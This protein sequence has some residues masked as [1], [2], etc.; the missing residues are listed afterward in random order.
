MSTAYPTH[1]QVE[2]QVAD[3]EVKQEGKINATISGHIYPIPQTGNTPA[4]EPA[5][6]KDGIYRVKTKGATYTNFGGVVVP[7]TT[8]FIYD[9][10]VSGIGV[11]P[12]YTL[13]E[14]D[15]NITTSNT[16]TEGGTNAFTD[17]GAF[18]EFAKKADKTEL[19]DEK[20]KYPF[21]ITATLNGKNFL[22][23]FIEDIKLINADPTKQYFLKKCQVDNSGVIHSI[24][25]AEEDGTRFAV[26]YVTG[27]TPTGKQLITQAATT[28][29]DASMEILVNWDNVVSNNSAVFTFD[30]TAL[31]KSVITEDVYSKI[32]PQLMPIPSF[33]N[34]GYAYIDDSNVLTLTQNLDIP[35][36]DS[37][38]TITS[39]TLD[40]QGK[41][42]GLFYLDYIDGTSTYTLDNITWVGSLTIQN[43]TKNRI[44]I[45]YT[46][47]SKL[48]S[49]ILTG[50]SDNRF[51]INETN[52][53]LANTLSQII[54][55]VFRN[56][57]KAVQTGT[58]F[59]IQEDVE[60]WYGTNRFVTITAGTYSLAGKNNRGA[61]YLDITGLD[62]GNPTHTVDDFVYTTDT[63]IINKFV[64]NRVYIGYIIDENI[65]TNLIKIGA[66]DLN[67]K[68]N[69]S[70]V[71]LKTTT[72]YG[73]GT[74]IVLF[75][76]SITEQN[77]AYTQSSAIYDGARG[78]WN[79]ANFF[80]NQR[81][82][83]IYNAG[84]GGDTTVGMLARIQADVIDKNPDVVFFMGGINDINTLEEQDASI[85]FGRIEQIYDLLTANGIKIIGSLITPSVSSIAW[86]KDTLAQLNK[87]LSDYAYSNP[88]LILVD[89]GKTIVDYTTGDPI[90][91]WTD[92]THPYDVAAFEM[93]WEVA[94]QIRPF[95]KETPF[96]PY[97]KLDNRLL[98]GN[99][100]MDGN[101][102]GVATGFVGTGIAGTVFT[103]E[104]RADRLGEWQVITSP[105]VNGSG[106]FYNLVSNPE[107][108]TFTQGDMIY[109]ACEIEADITEMRGIYFEIF[110]QDAGYGTTFYS[111]NLLRLPA[112][113]SPNI[114]NKIFKGT[115]KTEPFEIPATSTRIR[116]R[117]F[118]DF[119]GE[120]KVGRICALKV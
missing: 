97:S 79:M 18:T 35:F 65:Y 118:Y 42:R 102:S 9:I 88:N 12:V 56:D 92:N 36:R 63:N 93:G 107:D 87:L 64:P 20:Y 30:Q 32:D 61:V 70:D 68:A 50:G 75:G 109:G 38:I 89:M 71:L 96:L 99:A 100:F 11:T 60:F 103:K 85:I 80:L 40:L 2:Q 115:F 27:T 3:L 52:Y 83:K 44:I 73:T 6:T 104:V 95:F 98:N 91:N 120:I 43:L 54:N 114:E 19:F 31:L 58:D 47:E 57:G 111:A 59:I 10:Q 86:K 39:G 67:L 74:K 13:I 72:P 66:N 37:F 101:V 113:T 21:V 34:G 49:P 22:T 33:R 26:T 15:V 29:T 51:E 110:T 8:G 116:V 94:N 69:T 81:F 106:N 24:E 5:P 78:Y 82:T 62:V 28:Q 14:T 90:A 112:D 53:N 48:Y 23:K 45:G 17:G 55:P 108:L 25:I 105:S 16:P 76:D 84:I 46:N 7:N 4:N 41:T 1:A 117:L 77:G 119:A